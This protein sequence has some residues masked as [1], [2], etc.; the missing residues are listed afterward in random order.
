[1]SFSP[2]AKRQFTQQTHCAQTRIVHNPEKTVRLCPPGEVFCCFVSWFTCMHTA[3]FDARRNI[4]IV[5][6]IPFPSPYLQ[7]AHV[8]KRE[9]SQRWLGRT[10]QESLPAALHACGCGCGCGVIGATAKHTSISRYFTR[11]SI[12][13]RLVAWDDTRVAPWFTYVTLTA[14]SNNSEDYW[15]YRHPKVPPCHYRGV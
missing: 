8:N 14:I 3:T 4:A 10:K 2:V 9:R 11:Y 6:L 1:M 7:Q 13:R 12:Y 15:C 5:D